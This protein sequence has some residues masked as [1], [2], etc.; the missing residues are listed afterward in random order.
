MAD[1]YWRR[2]RKDVVNHYHGEKAF[3]I[4]CETTERIKKEF[5]ELAK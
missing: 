5:K 1:K 2:R 4:V 3:E